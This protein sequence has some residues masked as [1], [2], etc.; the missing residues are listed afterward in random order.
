MIS[1]NGT[2]VRYCWREYSE[3]NK[4][5]IVPFRIRIKLFQNYD[6]EINRNLL[7]TD[8]I[9]DFVNTQFITF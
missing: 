2:M 4:V 7:F 1:F 6:T 9:L 5:L 8:Y 3:E